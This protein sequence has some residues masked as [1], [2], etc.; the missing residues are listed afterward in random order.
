MPR[1]LRT[2]EAN[3]SAVYVAE[4]RKGWTFAP[5]LQYVVNPGGGYVLD[6]GQVK[7]VKNALVLG[8]RTV[9]KF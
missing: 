4:I 2:Y 1:P 8:A 5:T 3:V 6:N 9:L 7:A